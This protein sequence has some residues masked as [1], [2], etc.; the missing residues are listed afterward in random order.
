MGRP[1]RK[2]GSRTRT[3]DLQSLNKIPGSALPQGS[4][5]MDRSAI[6]N[7]APAPTLLAS[8]DQMWRRIPID[9][10]ATGARRHH[11][12]HQPL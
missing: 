2:A 8:Q 6:A 11:K 1:S 3:E 7:C 12:F 9:P 10:S 5:P 4:L